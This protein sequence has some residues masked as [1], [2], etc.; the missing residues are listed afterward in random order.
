MQRT[1]LHDAIRET[2]SELKLKMPQVAGPLRVAVTGRTATPSID[3]VL[4]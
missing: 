1:A 4:D 3:A 2:V